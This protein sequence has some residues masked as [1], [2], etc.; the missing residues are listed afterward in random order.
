MC[1]GFSSRC[2]AYPC[3]HTPCPT[4]PQTVMFIW[5]GE[6]TG[7]IERPYG[8]PTEGTQSLSSVARTM[9]SVMRG[10][11]ESSQ[12]KE[13]LFEAKRKGKNPVNSK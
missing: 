2:C 13:F 4:H 11:V 10:K 6:V 1:L 5:P 7:L 8:I 9:D 12:V 3:P